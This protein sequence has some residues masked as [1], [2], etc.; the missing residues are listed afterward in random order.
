MNTMT[1][2]SLTMTLAGVLLALC[3]AVHADDTQY[4]PDA[5]RWASI[6][7]A[8]AGMS[9]RHLDAALDYALG[10]NTKGALV[11]RHGRIVAERYAPDWTPDTPRA[12]ASA[13]KSLVAIVA[14]MAVDEGRIR[15]DQSAA[16]FF[17]AWRGTAKAAVTVRQFLSMTTGISDQ[18]LLSRR[19]PGCQTEINTAT[20]LEHPPG[21]AWKYNTPMYHLTMH[22]VERAV[23]V[24]FDA[25]MQRRLIDP[26]GMT[27]F[28]WL[29]DSN[30]GAGGPCT[31]YYAGEASTRDMARFGLFVARG[32]RWKDTRLV[33]EAFFAAATSPSQALNPGYGLLFWV[34]PASAATGASGQARISA[35]GAGGQSI[36]AMPGLDLVVVRQGDNPPDRGMSNRFVQ[37]VLDAVQ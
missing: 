23:A 24:P 17:P 3:A 8:E 7:P 34:Q 4:W 36:V 5:S 32:G 28:R 19:V 2:T 31:N 9:G 35:Q 25:Y 6:S 27:T 12:L 37:M 20:P 22:M 21:T 14:G 13:T 16:D 10:Q 11:L 33:S 18:G 30:T 15:L 26:L 1:K 29:K